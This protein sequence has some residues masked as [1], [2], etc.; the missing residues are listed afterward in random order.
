[1]SDLIT[2]NE[3]R[4]LIGK[5]LGIGVLNESVFKRYIKSGLLPIHV[6]SESRIKGFKYSKSEILM[7][8]DKIKRYKSNHNP[9]PIKSEGAINIHAYILAMSLMS[10][11]SQ[12]IR[13]R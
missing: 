3:A 11:K 8:I 7:R 5:E 10:V 2:R 1:M 9:N 12:Q 13:K 4:E 6:T